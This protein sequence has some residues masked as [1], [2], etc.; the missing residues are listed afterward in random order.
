M[1][2]YLEKSKELDW[3]TQKISAKVPHPPPKKNEANILN[4]WGL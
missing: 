1:G 3:L 2:V 4:G